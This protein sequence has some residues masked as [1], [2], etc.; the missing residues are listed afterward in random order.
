[1]KDNACTPVRVSET[2][3]SMVA[4]TAKMELNKPYRIRFADEDLV[5]VWTGKQLEL[6]EEAEGQ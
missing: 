5:V 1:M 4:D 6:Y 3:I 2:G